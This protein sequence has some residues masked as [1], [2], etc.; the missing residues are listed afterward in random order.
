MNE[1]KFVYTSDSYDTTRAIAAEFASKLCPGDVVTLDGDLGAGKTAFTGGLAMGLGIDRHVTSPTF[2]IVNEYHGGRLTLY[3]FDVYRLESMDDLYDIG[4]E[5]YVTNGGVCV[6]EWADIVR[7]G[8]DLP[9]YEIRI[10]KSND[11]EDMR[12]ISIVYKQLR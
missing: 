7:D 11:N 3:H 6:L 10:T 8:L 9:Y 12:E 2:T 5:D 1:Q 4:W